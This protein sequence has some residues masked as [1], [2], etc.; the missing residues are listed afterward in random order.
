VYWRS[1][2]RNSN[3]DPRRKHF[4][5]KYSRNV[6]QAYEQVSC[7]RPSGTVSDLRQPLENLTKAL[8]DMMRMKD[9]DDLHPIQRAELPQVLAETSGTSAEAIWLKV[10]MRYTYT[11]LLLL[12]RILWHVLPG[13]ADLWTDWEGGLKINEWDLV[14]ILDSD[15]S[16]TRSTPKHPRRRELLKEAK[17][18][19]EGSDMSDSSGGRQY[20]ESPCQ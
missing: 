18:D 3:L 11:C 12:I 2:L 4:Y 19:S 1:V 8:N 17:C 7:V 14:F 20:T 5:N 15:K 16:L 13:H 10:K 9:Y 6:V